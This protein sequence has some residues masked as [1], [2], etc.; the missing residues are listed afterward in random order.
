MPTLNQ[1]RHQSTFRLNKSEKGFLLGSRYT[2]WRDHFSS[3]STFYIL[4]MKQGNRPMWQAL[5]LYPSSSDTV[6]LFS[7]SENATRLAEA[8]SHIAFLIL[9]RKISHLV[10]F[11]FL[12]SFPRMT[13]ITESML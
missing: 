3:W 11:V 13:S 9:K 5:G 12:I 7:E 2:V 4:V 1:L 6:S 10:D 8:N